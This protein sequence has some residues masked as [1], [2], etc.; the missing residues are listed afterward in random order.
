MSNEG[1]GRWLTLS[2][3][4]GAALTL[5]TIVNVSAATGTAT[6]T[7]GSLAL[8]GPGA[9]TWSATLSG[10]DLSLGSAATSIV[11]DSSGSGAGWQ[12]TGDMSQFTSGVNHLSSNDVNVNGSAAAEVNAAAP[13][14]TCGAG[15]TCTLPSSTTAPVTYPVLLPTGSSPATLY[16][17][18]AATGM[19]VIDL[20]TEWWLSVPGNS[21]AGTYTSTFTLAMVSGP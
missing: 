15:S 18:N 21:L 9:V 6:L 14:A 10:S 3:V 19:G 8:S 7:A 20:A 4:A 11:T 13:T 5:A 1:N 2:V 17:A 12:F 16:T